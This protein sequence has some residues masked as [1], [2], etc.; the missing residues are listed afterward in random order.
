V[1]LARA[2]ARGV[3]GR[4][5]AT[6]LGV[7]ALCWQGEASPPLPPGD[8][9]RAL[10]LSRASLYRHLARLGETDGGLG[11]L[12]IVSRGRRLSLQP[13][14][15]VAPAPARRGVDPDLARALAAIGV[16]EPKRAALA[17]RAIDPLW[18]R[19]WHLW[20]RDPARRNL[21]NPVGAV[22]QQLEQGAPPPAAFLRAARREAA[23]PPVATTWDSGEAGEAEEAGPPPD[24]RD[25]L[26]QQTLAELATCLYRPIFDRHFRGSYV[27]PD[28]PGDDD[29]LTVT[30]RRA[31]SLPW[32]AGRLASTV[33]RCLARC[34]ERDID[35][36]FVAR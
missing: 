1:E 29:R 20:S 18:V 13:L 8:L 35:V 22:I 5:V 2:R 26:W 11:W 15:Q 25:A 32:L 7:L 16:E 30:V 4:L 23:L 33:R 36:R 17:R 24:G 34:A 12:R 10:G 9:A 19:A 28:S 31:D 6:M 21:A 27:D 14:L 3:D